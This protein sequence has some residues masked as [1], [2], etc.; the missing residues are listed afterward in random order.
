MTALALGLALCA[1]PVQAS[2]R[3]R[4]EIAGERVGFARLSVSC[5]GDRCEATWESALSLPESGGGGT[6]RRRIDIQADASGRARAVRVRVLAPEGERIAEAGAGPV[7]ASLAELLLADAAEGER[8]CIPVREEESG[9][10]GEACARRR[11]EWLEGEVLGEPI[12]FRA[13]PGALADEAILPGQ[14]ARFAA[15]AKATLPRRPP[16][17]Y[18]S[19]VPEEPEPGPFR[20]C[21]AA[22]EPE[23]S[24]PIPGRMPRAFPGG[25]SC[26]E[27]TARY[28][29]IAAGR[30]MAGRHVV[31]VA[32]DGQGFVWHEWAE[33]QIDGRWITADPSFRQVPAR[34]PRFAV[35]RFTSG[36]RAAR[37]SAGRRVLACWGR[38]RVV[39]TR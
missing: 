32:H 6:L 2:Q 36:D 8:R 31:G 35:A 14:G 28:L 17:M 11:G 26:R 21:G 18:G 3:Y 19:G 15:D 9:S 37:A 27:K 30:G 12:R 10:E 5:A 29:A 34:G 4:V 23:P 24:G 20:F 39:G 13:R 1:L 25:G 7:P 33:V 38:A 22:L 16:H